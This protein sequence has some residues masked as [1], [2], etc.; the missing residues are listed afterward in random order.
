M[1]IYPIYKANQTPCTAH[2]NYN[3]WGGIENNLKHIQQLNSS[4]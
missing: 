2:R 1:F 4:Y 3:G